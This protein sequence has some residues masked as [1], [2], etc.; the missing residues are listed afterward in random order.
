MLVTR[1]FAGIG[2]HQY[3]IQ[4]CKQK[5][6]LPSDGK[7]PISASSHG[8]RD[9]PAT[10]ADSPANELFLPNVEL[11]HPSEESSWVQMEQFGSPLQDQ[12]TQVKSAGNYLP[13]QPPGEVWLTLFFIW[14][15]FSVFQSIDLSQGT[16]TLKGATLKISEGVEGGRRTLLVAV[17]LK[18]S[19]VGIFKLGAVTPEKRDILLD[20]AEMADK[21]NAIFD[22]IWTAKTATSGQLKISHES[23]YSADATS[24]TVSHN[25][26]G[27][28]LTGILW[29]LSPVFVSVYCLPLTDQL[30]S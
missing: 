15:C 27:T 8:V 20:L 9:L 21:P 18:G 26:S 10:E 3:C 19:P 17:F 5:P 1:L 2:S 4:E 16:T 14:H 23:E 6:C 12:S 30:Y 28:L 11:W 7:Y 22:V 25:I 24:P 13:M 29:F